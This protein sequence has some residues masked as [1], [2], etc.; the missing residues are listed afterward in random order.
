MT[1]NTQ[2]TLDAFNTADEND[3]GEDSDVLDA[4]PGIRN[5]NDDAWYEYDGEPMWNDDTI[6]RVR[7]RLQTA[8]NTEWGR[9]SASPKAAALGNTKDE[10]TKSTKIKTEHAD[11]FEVAVEDKAKAVGEDINGWIVPELIPKPNVY[12]KGPVRTDVSVAY[13]MAHSVAMG[14]AAY[15]QQKIVKAVRD[16]EFWIYQ[17]RVI[18]PLFNEFN[19]KYPY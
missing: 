19:E 5:R 3:D 6:D 12:E 14:G 8:A 7:E 10:W 11:T 13:S 17:T 2:A 15:K 1:R 16:F 9:V 4:V 18:E